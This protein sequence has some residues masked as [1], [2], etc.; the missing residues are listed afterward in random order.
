MIFDNMWTLQH[1]NLP[2]N[3]SSRLFSNFPPLPEVK[4]VV[5]VWFQNYYSSTLPL[6]FLVRSKQKER[7]HMPF[8]RS[9][10]SVTLAK[11]E[12]GSINP[13]SALVSRE[14]EKQDLIGSRKSWKQIC[15]RSGCFLRAFRQ[16][17][18]QPRK[19]LSENSLKNLFPTGY[20]FSQ[21]H[22]TSL[23]PL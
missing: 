22:A 5:H 8:F 20:N 18:T 6:E 1:G 16:G 12:R 19:F 13:E 15:F 17:S 3:C 23:Q 2:I 14:E 9:T 7:K 4:P 11:R 10:K 21:M